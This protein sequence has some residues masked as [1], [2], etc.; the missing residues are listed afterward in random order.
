MYLNPKIALL[1]FLLTGCQQIEPSSHEEKT[2]SNKFKLESVKEDN[3]NQEKAVKEEQPLETITVTPEPGIEPSNL[4]IPALE[5]EAST[6]PVGLKDDGTV[7]IPSD[8]EIVGWFSNGSKPG[9]TGNTV[10]V[11]H[12]NGF[13]GPGVFSNLYKISTNDEIV[14]TNGKEEVVYKVIKKQ[15]YPYDQGPIEE[16]FGY[17]SKTRLQLITCTGTFNPLKGTHEERL[18]VTAIAN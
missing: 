15:S 14:I 4:S 1:L 3:T 10:L 8:I 2:D 9:Q 5:I 16:I 7:E 11:G 18:V 12:V 17:T 13:L 6:I